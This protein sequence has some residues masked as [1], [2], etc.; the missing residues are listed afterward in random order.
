MKTDILI[1]GG[2]SIGLNCAYYLLKSGRK[3]TI[4][5]AHE[6][7]QGNVSGN[8]GQIVPSH[9]I[10]LAAPGVASS[11]L[12]WM[13][14]EKTSPFGMAM[15]FDI[16]YV[17]WLVQFARSCNE[18]NLKRG[19]PAMKNLGQLSAGNFQKIITEENIACHYGQTGMIT[20][21][22]D[23]KTFSAGVHDAEVL[24]T[25]GI[26]VQVLDKTAL[27]ALEPNLQNDVI[28]GTHCKQDCFVNPALF[29]KS[30]SERVREMGAEIF[31]H[32]PVTGF[33]IEN[34]KITKVK[35]AEKIFEAEQIILA[36][37]VWSPQLARDLKLQIPVQPARGYS[38]TIDSIKQ[39]P[40]H[41]FTLGDR[42]VAVT[43]FGNL[44]RV[45]GRLEVGQFDRTPN[46][47]WIHRLE[48]FLR[49]YFVL[50]E[51]INIVETWA[52]LRPVTPDG[53]PI[54]GKSPL[55][56]NLIV[57]TGHAM[58]GLTLGPATGQIVS[59]LVNGKDTAFDI[60]PFALERFM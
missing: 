14:N 11:A 47:K 21:F 42:H 18:A 38:L 50:D 54:I 19:I 57:A 13:L 46:P 8:A 26:A 31:E 15:R 45:T 40:Q 43:P 30:L 2:S 37:G 41:A 17:K 12:K 36:T 28:G 48:N 32:T 58:L 24:Q 7:A 35:T 4:L 56:T 27:H 49:E 60:S 1:I 10:P 9:I 22:K 34:K 3:V 23:A 53:I 52:G 6:V 25:H 29:L 5:E 44:L 59:E 55:H 16:D 39:M 51:K 20:L 33:E